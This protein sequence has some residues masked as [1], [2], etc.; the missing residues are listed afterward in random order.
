M[1]LF[2]ILLQFDERYKSGFH[3]KT[4]IRLKRRE[5]DL[6][7]L[8]SKDPNHVMHFYTEKIRLEPGSFTY[9]VKVLED[10]GLL[11]RIDNEL[12]KREKTLVLTKKG[13]EIAEDVV[14]QMETYI[15]SIM[16]VY[17]EDERERLNQAMMTLE[18]LLYKLPKID[19]RRRKR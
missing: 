15:D 2:D 9:L 3:P 5:L 6:L 19:R 7:V 11:T 18:E 1:M 13:N 12:N 14:N 10:K 8:M 17:T 4:K 16:C